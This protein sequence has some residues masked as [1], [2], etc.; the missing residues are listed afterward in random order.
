MQMELSNSQCLEAPVK[1]SQGLAI[2]VK[3]KVYYGGGVC[4][5]DDQK[6]YIHCFDPVQH[7]WSTL[8]RVSVRYFGLGEIRNELVTV[9]G[10]TSNNAKTGALN[11]YNEASQNWKRTIKPMPTA[12][13][14]PAVVSLPTGLIVAGG[15]LHTKSKSEIDQESTNIVEIYSIKT[16]QWQSTY[17][18]PVTSNNS[19]MVT[20]DN[21]VYLIGGRDGMKKKS[22]KVFTA[23]VDESEPAIRKEDRT[24]VDHTDSLICA[25]KEV[26][27]T[28]FFCPS[29]GSVLAMPLALGGQDDNDKPAQGIHAY[30]P[31]SN[32]WVKIGDLPYSVA[33]PAIVSLTSI[34]FLMIGGEDVNKTKLASVTKIKLT[35]SV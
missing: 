23:L 14:S 7:K 5:N 9:G 34:E 30:S 28:P 32:S 16:E 26:T 35:V 2:V 12:R 20:C 25:W 24:L 22:S 18:L 21:T 1:M 4:Q 27:S 6:Y 33:F 13:N 8:V 3:G 10:S 31:S 17:S 11:V 29:A 19:K 15:W